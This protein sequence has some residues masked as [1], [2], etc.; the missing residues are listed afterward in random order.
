[1][2]EVFG[3]LAQ[4][5]GCSSPLQRSAVSS[6]DYSEYEVASKIGHLKTL[7][8]RLM[9][10]LEVGRYLVYGLRTGQ[11]LFSLFVRA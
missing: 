2:G 7:H 4:S 3:S 11:S 10:V 5:A 9:H 8:S 6:L 1:M